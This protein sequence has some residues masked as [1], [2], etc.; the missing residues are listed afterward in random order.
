MTTQ[1]QSISDE[2]SESE[3]VEELGFLIFDEEGVSMVD[4][5][6]LD[7]I[8]SRQEAFELALS[9]F[10]YMYYSLE[11]EGTMECTNIIVIN[12]K[13]FGIPAELSRTIDE[14]DLRWVGIKKELYSAQRKINGHK[15][16]YSC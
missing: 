12:G 6:F 11:G 2:T 3:D 7:A 4:D 1:Q 8:K 13:D 15:L 9:C 10:D 5:E 14:L 16:L